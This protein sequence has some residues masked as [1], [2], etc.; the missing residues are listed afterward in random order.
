M[1]GSGDEE[2]NPYLITLRSFDCPVLLALAG[3]L[4]RAE[5]GIS[6]LYQDSKLGIC[7]APFPTPF[8]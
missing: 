4:A 7:F 6:L 8:I 2:N 5:W 1:W 3:R